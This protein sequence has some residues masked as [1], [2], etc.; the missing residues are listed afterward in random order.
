MRRAR[1][2]LEITMAFLIAFFAMS[3]FLTAQGAQKG[4]PPTPTTAK[5]NLQDAIAGG[6]KWKADAILTQINGT[7]VGAD[8]KLVSW[9]YAFYSPGSKTCAAVYAMKGQSFAQPTNDTMCE[10]VE[11]KEFLDSDKAI[12]TAHQNGITKPQCNMTVMIEKGK[13]VWMVMDGGGTSPGDV[14]LTIDATSGAVIGTM[15]Q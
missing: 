15:R 2:A 12:A 14:I 6:K 4:P 7:R 11:L 13:P 5:A 3:T 10:K 9:L 8:G 1:A